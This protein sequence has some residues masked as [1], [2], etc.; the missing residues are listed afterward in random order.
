MEKYNCNDCKKIDFIN[1]LC[2][3]CKK[4][5]RTFK[6]TNDWK[7][8]KYHKKCYSNSFDT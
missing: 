7:T 2:L 5:L 8:R 3:Y 1:K 6:K 4:P